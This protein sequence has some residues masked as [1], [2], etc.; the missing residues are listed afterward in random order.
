MLNIWVSFNLK[1]KN[2]RSFIMQY[3]FDL[4]FVNDICLSKITQRRIFS[5]PEFTIELLKGK[6]IL[7]SFYSFMINTTWRLLQST[8]RTLNRVCHAKEWPS[9]CDHTRKVHQNNLFQT[10][11]RLHYQPVG[12]VEWMWLI[13]MIYAMSNLKWKN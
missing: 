8:Y 4:R 11:Y 13:L 10:N 1:V 2:F 3:D 5:P 6:I 7:C 12:K 9:W